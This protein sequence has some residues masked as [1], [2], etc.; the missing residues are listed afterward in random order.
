MLPLHTVGL[1]N[2]RGVAISSE[3]ADVMMQNISTRDCTRVRDC[4]LCDEWF[5]GGGGGGDVGEGAPG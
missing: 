1:T 5:E 4:C 2:C 3:A